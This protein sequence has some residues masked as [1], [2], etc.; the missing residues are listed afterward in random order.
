MN[1]REK[2]NLTETIACDFLSSQGYTII[3]RN[4]L[5]R[6]GELDVVAKKDNALH[7]IEVKSDFRVHQNDGYRAEEQVHALKQ[8]RLRRVIST[9]LVE[10]KYGL[11]HPFVFDLIIVSF[12]KQG[13][14][15]EKF[16]IEM[17]ENIII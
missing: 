5:R 7:F 8:R 11:D 17:Q 6:W 12:G 15:I 16:N 4:Y 13:S 10:R 1:T 3:E 9:Y 14:N 2:G